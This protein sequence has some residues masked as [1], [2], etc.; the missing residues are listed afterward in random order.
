MA[1]KK[2]YILT[3]E[4]NEDEDRCEYVEEKLIDESPEEPALIGFLDLNEYFSESDMTCIL[5][6][7]I[8]KS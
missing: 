6:H 8:G 1:N 5:K 4:Y 3:I 2:R 7:T